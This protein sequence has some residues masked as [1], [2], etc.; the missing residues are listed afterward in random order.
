MTDALIIATIFLGMSS[1]VAI[2]LAVLT[3]IPT[4]AYVARGW[5]RLKERELELRRLEVAMRVRE[6]HLLPNYVDATNPDQLLA[7]ARADAEVLHAG[8]ARRQ[9]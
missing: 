9:H 2:P 6:N 5:L 7:W 4:L 1:L 8:L 3:G